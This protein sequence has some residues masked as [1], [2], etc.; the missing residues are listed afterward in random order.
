[1][2]IFFNKML[3]HG[4]DGNCNDIIKIKMLMVMMVYIVVMILLKSK[5]LW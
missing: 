2:G 3:M 1:M 5:C 4:D